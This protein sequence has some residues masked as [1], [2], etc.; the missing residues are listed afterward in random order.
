MKAHLSS[1][2]L[3]C[4]RCSAAL[5]LVHTA[6]DQFFECDTA[7]CVNAGKRYAVPTIDLQEIGDDACADDHR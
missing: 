6:S 3:H 2:T 7:D 1:M 4:E 5:V